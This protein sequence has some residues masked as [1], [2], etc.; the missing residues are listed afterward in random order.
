MW[1]F[2][3]VFDSS[4]TFPTG[5]IF[6][7]PG[8]SGVGDRLPGCSAFAQG[9]ALVW[10]PFAGAC[11]NFWETGPRPWGAPRARTGLLGRG[12]AGS[13]L[14]AVMGFW[15]HGVGSSSLSGEIQVWLCKVTVVVEGEGISELSG[16][17]QWQGGRGPSALWRAVH[18]GWN[19]GCL[20]RGVLSILGPGFPCFLL[21]WT[22]VSPGARVSREGGDLQVEKL[23]CW[24]NECVSEGTE[25]R[26]QPFSREKI[27]QFDLHWFYISYSAF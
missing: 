27:V 25:V 26:H 7:S 24:V 10:R 9:C 19:L 2:W 1:L 8:I 16:R 17:R 3:C 11:R 21:G 23:A 12:E 5:S 20:H 22:S 6:F 14:E 15:G 18:W 4:N 13:E